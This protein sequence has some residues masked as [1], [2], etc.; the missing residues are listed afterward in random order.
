MVLV[1]SPLIGGHAYPPPFLSKFCCFYSQMLLCSSA[2]LMQNQVQSLQ[3]K[4]IAA[5]YLASSRT[6][7]E[8]RDVLQR[9]EAG[10]RALEIIFITPESV[11]AEP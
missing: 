8:R 9:L 6:S 1:V 2:A 3:A 7:L 4:G 5:D 11:T 10:N